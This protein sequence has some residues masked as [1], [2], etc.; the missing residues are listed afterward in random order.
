MV[1][2]RA[3]LP[4]QLPAIE[5]SKPFQP[6]MVEEIIRHNFALACRHADMRSKAWKP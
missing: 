3:A 4:L 2:A 6:V 5:A 1:R